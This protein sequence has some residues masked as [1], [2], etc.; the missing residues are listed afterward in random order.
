MMR[1]I[2]LLRKCRMYNYIPLFMRSILFFV[3]ILPAVASFAQSE[4]V[5]RT[6][7]IAQSEKE[8]FDAVRNNRAP[9]NASGNFVV[10]YYRCE[11]NVDPA[12]FF[13][14]GAVTSYFKITSDSASSIVYDLSNQL[15]VDSVIFR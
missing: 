1:Y 15:T 4:N 2:V 3:M 12:V 13:I 6:K 10:N 8:K 14:K 9:S 5:E 7:Q 11:W